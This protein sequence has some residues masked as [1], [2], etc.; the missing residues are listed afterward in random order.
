M[1]PTEQILLTGNEAL[2]EA[3]LRAGCRAYYGYPITPQSQILETMARRMKDFGGVFIQT[4]SEIAA[5]NA[6]YG[7]S[8][9]GIRSMTSSASTAWS[10]KQ[11]GI[12]HLAYM[13][14][15]AVIVNTMRGGP[16]LGNPLPSQGDYLQATK[17]GGSGD[18]NVLVLAPNSVQ[19]VADLTVTAFDLSDKYR[20]PVVMLVDGVIART[21]ESLSLP[22]P[23]SIESLPEKN[24]ALTGAQGRERR[25]IEP[26]NTAY[27]LEQR[28]LHLQ[29]KFNQIKNNEMRY[30]LYQVEDAEIVLCAYGICSRICKLCVIEARKQGIKVGLFRPISLWPFPME[31]VS[32]LSSHIKA[33]FVLEMNA[34]QM[35]WD[36]QFGARGKVPVYFHGRT[37]GMLPSDQDLL[38]A[39]SIINA[40]EKPQGWEELKIG[41]GIWKTA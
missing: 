34:G 10:L 32:E 41:P 26:C 28:N 6:V 24:W 1:K 30:E 16:G 18:Y 9:A 3:A 19:E 39:L 21:M 11:E 23:I 37:G 29:R 36:I 40:H 22:E 17:G 13:E 27:E 15:P 8:A 35:W 25:V 12:S 20:N 31:I 4:E 5:I 7:S 33:F 2:A 14:L 38:Q